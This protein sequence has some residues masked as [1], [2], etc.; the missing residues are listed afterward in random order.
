M[1]L[2][3]LLLPSSKNRYEKELRK[4]AAG[5]GVDRLKIS[6]MDPELL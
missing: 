2:K 4:E 6:E 3:C 5:Q 1:F